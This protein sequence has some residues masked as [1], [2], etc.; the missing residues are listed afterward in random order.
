[1]VL[2]TVGTVMMAMVPKPE[3]GR[4]LSDAGVGGVRTTVRAESLFRINAEEEDRPADRKNG[5]GA[6][7]WLAYPDFKYGNQKLARARRGAHS[8]R[9]RS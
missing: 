6:S 5:A 8:V 1:M 9:T 2:S 7:P 4:A 3:G